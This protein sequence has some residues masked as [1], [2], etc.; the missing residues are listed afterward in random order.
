MSE[1][2]QVRDILN[3]DGLVIHAWPKGM[4]SNYPAAEEHFAYSFDDLKAA[5][6]PYLNGDNPRLQFDI[7]VA[8]GRHAG[9]HVA[10]GGVEQTAYYAIDLPKNSDV[11]R[12]I[13]PTGLFLEAAASTDHLAAVSNDYR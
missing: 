12:I 3:K 4:S 13:G 11:K 10:S 2:V 6:W 1:A 5:L 9:L 7:E 8:T